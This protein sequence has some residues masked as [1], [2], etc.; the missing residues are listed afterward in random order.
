MSEN[1]KPSNPNLENSPAENKPPVSPAT[2][3]DKLS[4]ALAEVEK[5]KKEV[6]KM[7]EGQIKREQELDAREAKLKGAPEVDVELVREKHARKV[8]VMKEH[9]KKQPKVRM[10]IPLEGSEKIGATVPITLNGY[11]VNV[12][13]GVYVDVPEQIS[14]MIEESFNQTQKAGENFRIDMKGK[15]VQEALS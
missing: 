14:K 15:N 6:E 3:D 12:P 1:K 7:Q 10:M 4:K 5:M 13:K 9:L 8:D 2:P 11:R